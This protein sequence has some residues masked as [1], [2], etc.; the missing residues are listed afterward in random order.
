[1]RFITL[2]LSSLLVLRLFV[3]AYFISQE[4]YMNDNC[5]VLLLPVLR[6]LARNI[7]KGV[8]LRNSK[9]MS[10]LRSCNLYDGYILEA[11]LISTLSARR[12]I[13]TVRNLA[14]GQPL[15]EYGRQ[16]TFL[17]QTNQLFSFLGS[18][19][20]GKSCAIVK[21]YGLKVI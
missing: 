16:L 10:F 7:A 11:F 9:K 8:T 1:M 17:Q 2:I 12:K 14:L 15:N 18:E 6:Q 20:K 4:E 5:H 13:K 21:G 19:Q 3:R